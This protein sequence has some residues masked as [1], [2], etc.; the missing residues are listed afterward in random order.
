MIRQWAEAMEPFDHEM[1]TEN[2]FE[3]RVSLK[4]RPSIA[5][6]VG[7]DDNW[8]AQ[9]AHEFMKTPEAMHWSGHN[10]DDFKQGGDDV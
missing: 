5:E 6:M 9:T 10:P 1:V 2:F 7:R 3:L 8:E 4:F